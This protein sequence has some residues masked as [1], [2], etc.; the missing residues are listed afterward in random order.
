[1]LRLLTSVY[2]FFFNRSGFR[3]ILPQCIAVGLP[4]D[5]DNQYEFWLH[6]GKDDIRRF[7]IPGYKAYNCFKPI[8]RLVTGFEFQDRGDNTHL[9]TFDPTYFALWYLDRQPDN[10]YFSLY[11][12]TNDFMVLNKHKFLIERGS[13][14]S[15][16][17]EM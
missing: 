11:D 4:M 6:C 17:G 10:I 14:R 8:D 7:D 12:K 5:E 15:C 3:Y 2:D 16:P 9:I 13:C 1:M